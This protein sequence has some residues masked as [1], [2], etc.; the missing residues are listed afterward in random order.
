[1]IDVQIEVVLMSQYQ[2]PPQEG[3]LEVL[4]LIFNFLSNK[5]RKILVMDP[6]V[7]YVEEYIFNLNADWKEFYRDVVEEDPHRMYEPLGNPVY[8]G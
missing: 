3:H 4:Y 6:S 2:A 5:P 8:I 7:P 1:M